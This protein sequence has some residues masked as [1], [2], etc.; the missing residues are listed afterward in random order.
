MAKK[1]AVADLNFEQAFEELQKVVT[2]LENEQ[3]ALEEALALFERGQELAKQC[4]ALLEKA[5]L[6]VQ[7][8]TEEGELE[9]LKE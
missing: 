7:Q 6:R 1:T 3:H 2:A 4:S 8:L 9:E 5:E